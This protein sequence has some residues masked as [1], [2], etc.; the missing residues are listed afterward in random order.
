MGDD[1]SPA[2]KKVEM[3]ITNFVKKM[4]SA[5]QNFCKLESNE[6]KTIGIDMSYRSIPEKARTRE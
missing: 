6:M 3:N 1:K 2:L 4:N 5:K